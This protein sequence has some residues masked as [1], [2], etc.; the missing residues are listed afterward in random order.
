MD[1]A[2]IIGVDEAGRGSLW[3]RVYAG[4]VCFGGVVSS[5][6]MEKAA[7]NKRVIRDSK[8]MTALARRKSREYI[9]NE[10]ESMWGVGYASEE[11]VDQLGIVPANT[12]A[13][14]RAIDNLLQKHPVLTE[15][16]TTLR[17]DGTFFRDYPNISHE[18]V[19]RGESAYPEIAAAS[20]L[21]KTHRDAYVL[22]SCQS[23]T[24][25][26]RYCLETNMGYGTAAHL[27]AL[28]EYGPTPL[29]RQ[30]FVRKFH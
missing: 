27:E 19:I 29:H 14:H 3:G 25:L 9:E 15:L 12:L 6:W 11:E 26:T 20:I 10:S 4:A 24:S 16:Q 13:M 21:A 5:D 8:K 2:W 22:D 23:N 1:N 30:T 18:L 28:R 7:K 17:V